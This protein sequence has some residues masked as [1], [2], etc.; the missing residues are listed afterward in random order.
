MN[1]ND[2]ATPISSVFIGI[3]PFLFYYI[4]KNGKSL[5]S[6]YTKVSYPFYAYLR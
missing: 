1:Q 2:F 4:A 6:L 5:L 3:S